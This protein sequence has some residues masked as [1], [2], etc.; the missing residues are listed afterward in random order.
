MADAQHRPRWHRELPIAVV[1][2]VLTGVVRLE[3]LRESRGYVLIGIF[4]WVCVLKSGVHATLAGVAVALAV[5]LA[6]TGQTPYSPLKHIKETLHPWVAFG[7][8][9]VFAF[10]NAGVSGKIGAVVD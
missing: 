4:I 2:L 5:P 6:V 8:L 10:A 7:V 1:L 3:K 9:P